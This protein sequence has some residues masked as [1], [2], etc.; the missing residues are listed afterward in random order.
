MQTH[1]RTDP[2]LAFW[3]N[4]Y[5]LHHEKESMANLGV[6]STAMREVAESQDEIGWVDFFTRQGIN[7]NHPDSECPLCTGGKQHEWQQ[8][9]N[10]IHTTPHPHLAFTMAV[11]ELH[12]APPHQ[13]VPMQTR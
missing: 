9:D 4:E 8:L 10:T 2:K 7:Q 6:M 3:I 12:P 13:R 1:N 11:P 5:L